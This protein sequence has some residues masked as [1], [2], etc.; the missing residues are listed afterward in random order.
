MMICL[1]VTLLLDGL[2]RFLSGKERSYRSAAVDS[3]FSLGLHA[4]G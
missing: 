2:R 4:D 1:S 3:S